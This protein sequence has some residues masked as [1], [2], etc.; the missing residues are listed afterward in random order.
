[1]KATASTGSNAR[2]GD[3]QRVDEPEQQGLPKAV[4]DGRDDGLIVDREPGRWSKEAE[5]GAD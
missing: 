3:R 5:T 4:V 1:M 2:S